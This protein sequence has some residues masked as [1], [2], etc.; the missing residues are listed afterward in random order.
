MKL[1]VDLD[2][3]TSFQALDESFAISFS[4]LEEIQL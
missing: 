1:K 4:Q 3:T 2:V